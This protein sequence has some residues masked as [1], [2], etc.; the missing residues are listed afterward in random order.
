MDGRPFTWSLGPVGRGYLYVNEHFVGLAGKARLI[1]FPEFPHPGDQAG[2]VEFSTCLG[3]RAWR[4]LAD[5]ETFSAQRAQWRLKIAGPQPWSFPELVVE[6]GL[7]T[8]TGDG[9]LSVRSDWDLVDE[10][11]RPWSFRPSSPRPDVSLF[12]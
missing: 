5:L 1:A 3:E 2:F 11:S 6:E 10:V 7:G 9:H 8:P 4:R 12:R